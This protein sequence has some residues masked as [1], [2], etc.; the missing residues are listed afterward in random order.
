VHDIDLHKAF[1]LYQRSRVA[2]TARIV[3]SARKMG[4][5]FHARGVERLVRND[6]WKGRTPE[7]FY[8]AMEWLYGWKLDNCLAA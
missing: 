8:D 4:R 2:R 1:A 7:R 5:I 3:L 6:L